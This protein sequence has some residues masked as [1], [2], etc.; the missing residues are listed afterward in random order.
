MQPD[1]GVTAS[2]I[3]GAVWVKSSSSVADG[4]CVE[5]AELSGGSVAVRNSRFPDGPALVF[6]RAELAA[7]LTGARNSEF[8]HM[9]G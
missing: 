3:P 7:F 4:N 2:E 5:V 9:T 8:D 6:T 1:N